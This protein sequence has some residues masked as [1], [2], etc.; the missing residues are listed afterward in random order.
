LTNVQVYGDA[1]TGSC[2]C[3]GNWAGS[4]C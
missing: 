4:S 3:R 2:S 1:C